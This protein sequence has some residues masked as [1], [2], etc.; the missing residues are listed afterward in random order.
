MLRFASGDRI[1]AVIVLGKEL[2][3][4]PE[5][6]RAELRARAA[7][8]AVAWAQGVPIVVALEARLRGQDL[9]GSVMVADDL[10]R[11]GVPESAMVLAECTRST[12]EEALAVRARCA[13]HSWRHILVISAAY[14]LPRARRYFDE[15]MAGVRVE[16]ATPEDML[17]GAGASERADILAAETSALALRTEHRAERVLTV[18]EALL[19]PLPRR[20]R[21]GLEVKAGAWLRGG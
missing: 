10:R 3:R 11:H 5:R 2:R 20:W 21:W 13:A 7:A 17:D 4:D 8:A 6:G 12:R 14:H 1:D 15:V 18:L 19:M 16:L 9:A